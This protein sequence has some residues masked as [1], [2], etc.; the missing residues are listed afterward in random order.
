MNADHLLDIITTGWVPL[1]IF[2]VWYGLNMVQERF[3][4]TFEKPKMG[5][6][7]L[8][9]IP[10]I[11]CVPCSFV[12]GPWIPPE[13]TIIE[14]LILGCFMGIAAYNFGGIANRLGIDKLLNAIGLGPKLAAKKQD[15][16]PPATVE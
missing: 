2:L 13:T 1:F 11:V 9:F 16:D 6:R 8:P 4:E 3:S 10:L 5:W 12:P 7:L 14:K 15:T